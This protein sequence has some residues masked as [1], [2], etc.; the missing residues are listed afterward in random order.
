M[1]TVL[2]SQG[3]ITAPFVL[4]DGY[5][6]APNGAGNFGDGRVSFVVRALASTT[7]EVELEVTSPNDKNDSFLL[8]FVD[9]ADFTFHTGIQQSWTWKLAGSAAG[10]QTW[11][12]S[13][14]EHTFHVKSRE[15]GTKLRAV[16][17]VTGNAVFVVAGPPC[18]ISLRLSVMSRTSDLSFKGRLDRRQTS[19][20]ATAGA[21][22]RTTSRIKARAGWLQGVSR[23][24]IGRYGGLAV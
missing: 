3:S 6:W 24:G 13:A 15:D 21:T 20:A 16:R 2:A 22:E 19:T 10:A 4:A 18:C 1:T 7:V 11:S 12:L 8:A 5:V 23:S 9:G 14:G 17:I